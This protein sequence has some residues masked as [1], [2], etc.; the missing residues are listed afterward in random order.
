[1]SSDRL[2]WRIYSETGA[3][4]VYG[5]MPGGAK[6]RDNLMRFYGQA[7]EFETN[8]YKGLFAFSAMLRRM[9]ELGQEPSVPAAGA[10]G[11]CVQIMTIH[12]SKGLEFPVVFVADMAGQ[13][14]LS[15]SA[16]PV[17]FH[18]SLDRRRNKI[19]RPAPTHH[20]FH[21]G[22]NGHRPSDDG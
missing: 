15:D 3:L 10:A 4:A 2:V 14:N 18:S 8:G 6:K 22:T 5:A 13:F 1:M 12:K 16:K 20:I 19:H 17:L 11:D 9:M 21:T 7:A